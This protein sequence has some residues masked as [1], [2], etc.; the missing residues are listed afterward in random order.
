MGFA[1]VMLDVEGLELNSE[2]KEVILHPNVGGVI[3]FSRNFA[4]L[5]QLQELVR[6][7]KSC[8]P[9]IL[10]SVDQEGGRVQRL[11]DEFSK[12][13]PLREFG[14]IFDKNEDEGLTVAY[15]IAWLMAT[16][17]LSVGI[18][19]SFAPVLDLDLGL[20][21]IIGD[22]AFHSNPEKASIIAKFYIKGMNAAGMKAIGKH[23]PGH[24]SVA[25]DSHLE[26]PED[27]RPLHEIANKDLMPFKNMINEGLDAIMP[28][29]IVYTQVDS[30]PACFSKVWLKQLLRDELNFKGAVLSDDLSMQGASIIGSHLER[31]EVALA[32]GCDMVLVCN[33]REN[34]VKVIEGLGDVNSRESSIRLQQLRG[35]K[36]LTFKELIESPRWLAASAMLKKYFK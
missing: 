33:D 13:P 22:R 17:V 2:D 20:S 6:E 1:R 18:D 3:L 9:N 36:V 23:F 35:S 21:G 24:G 15:N 4:N 14:K 32:N 29:H 12:L 5:E 34:A 27:T 10:V 25:P 7:I 26:L 16:E 11:K 31:A 28:A 8:K 19:F 30:K